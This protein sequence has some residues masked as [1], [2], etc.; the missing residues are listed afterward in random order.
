[1]KT[2]SYQN[3]Q[4]QITFL[5]KLYGQYFSV[6]LNLL[7]FLVRRKREIKFINKRENY[8]SNLIS[9]PLQP[10]WFLDLKELYNNNLKYGLLFKMVADSPAWE[11]SLVMNQKSLKINNCQ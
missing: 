2:I 10:R 4:T 11:M 5:Y 7:F 1:M 8:N 3:K 9:F 6:S